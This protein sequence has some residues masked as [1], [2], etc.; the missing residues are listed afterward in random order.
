MLDSLLTLDTCSYASQAIEYLKAFE[1][2]DQHLKAM[3]ATNLAFIYFLEGKRKRNILCV[4][5]SLEESRQLSQRIQLSEMPFSRCR[6]VC[7]FR[8]R[9]STVGEFKSADSYADMAIRYNRYNAKALVNKGNCLFMS[10]EY[11]RAKETFLEAVGVE[12]NIPEGFA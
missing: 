10:K 4:H 11:G 8:M 12:V 1:K 6:N 2:K 5:Y 7:V 9:L 3:A